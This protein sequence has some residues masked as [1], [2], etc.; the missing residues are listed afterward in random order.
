MSNEIWD[1][2]V[3]GRPLGGAGVPKIDG[4]LDLRDLRVAEPFAVETTRTQLADVTAL[5]G[6][7]SV[8]SV[9]WHSI[10][11]SGSLLPGLRFLDCQIHNCV[12]DRCRMSDLRVWRTDFADV[13]F[14]SAN[15]RGAVLGG[16]SEAFA[17]DARSDQFRIVAV[18]FIGMDDL[19]D[20]I[21][22][23]SNFRGFLEGL[24]TSG[25]PFLSRRAADGG[26]NRRG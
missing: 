21:V 7:T 15:L 17:F 5:G 8:R 4:R 11:F 3:H 19:R 2:L 14:R 18:P 6:I 9:S 23:A 25:I 1:A 12:F 24:F 16:T 10:D 22:I 13:S 20:A 26:A